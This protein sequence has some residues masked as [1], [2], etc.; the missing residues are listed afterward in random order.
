MVAF[1]A[2]IVE[3]PPHRREVAQQPLVRNKNR[4]RQCPAGQ[5]SPRRNTLGDINLLKK[6]T[7]CRN[8]G[9]FGTLGQQANLKN[10]KSHQEGKW[11][12]EETTM[13]SP[14]IPAEMRA[15]AERSFEQA[16]LA[17]DKFMDAAQC[18]SGWINARHQPPASVRFFCS[19]RQ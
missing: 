9:T 10:K 11:Q 19:N 17:F 15:F 18:E 3:P 16:K 8:V 1:V 12:K 5:Y 13:S 2:A 7:L 4:L 14:E 6:T